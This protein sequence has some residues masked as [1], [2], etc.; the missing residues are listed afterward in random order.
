MSEFV[1]KYTKR[2]QR[3][4]VCEPIGLL[5]QCHINSVNLTVVNKNSLDILYPTPALHGTRTAPT[6]DTFRASFVTERNVIVVFLFIYLSF[7][8]LGG[9]LQAIA[10]LVGAAEARR[11]ALQAGLHDA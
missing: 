4:H 2:K 11:D 6:N 7:F 10:L 1:Y 9:I 3:K 8:L 5:Y